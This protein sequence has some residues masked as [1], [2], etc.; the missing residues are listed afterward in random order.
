MFSW[1]Q[2]LKETKSYFKSFHL[3]WELGVGRPCVVASRFLQIQN[4]LILYHDRSL[5]LFPRTHHHKF[6]RQMYILRAEKCRRFWWNGW[7][8]KRKGTARFQAAVGLR[9]GTSSCHC[10][11]C[12]KACTKIQWIWFWG[13]LSNIWRRAQFQKKGISNGSWFNR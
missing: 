1:S 4:S 11:C 7:H 10:H 9:F 8:W 12:Y 2:W 6:Y 5:I 3:I 13:Y